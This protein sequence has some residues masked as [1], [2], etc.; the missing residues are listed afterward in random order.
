MFSVLQGFTAIFFVVSIGFI[1]GKTK[2]LGDGAEVVLS[3]L[4]FYVLTPALLFYSL[5]TTNLSVIFST[6]LVVA[7][8]S[9]LLIG[10]VYLLLARRVL[11]R[12]Y[13]ESIIGA[14]SSSYVN[15]ANLGIPIAIFVLHDASFVAPLLLFQIMIY[16]PL[17]LTTLDLT[18][19]TRKISYRQILFTPF[20][21]PI[22]IGGGL[23]L[24]VN[25]ADFSVPQP[26][27]Q[28]ISMLGNASVPGALLA[29]GISL[30]GAAVLQKGISPRREVALASTLKMIGQ[31]ILVFLLAK[32]LMGDS[33]HHLFAQVVIAALPTAQNVFVYA[34]KYDR[35]TI[36]A[37]DCGFLTTLASVP[38]I[39]LVA[40][41]LV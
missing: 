13:P 8:S 26:L 34:T 10:L 9:A 19:R 17:A 16:S 11:R 15:S 6:T 2:V 4:I 7:G 41:L 1:L 31:P 21:N 33:G 39:G 29:F 18:T 12:P 30:A 36:L 40:F 14:L 38:I 22:V 37:R 23:G 24:L 28:P 32:F 3:R 35:G 5:A 27:M 25:I 20:T